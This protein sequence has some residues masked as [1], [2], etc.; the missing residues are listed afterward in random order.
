MIPHSDAQQLAR[1]VRALEPLAEEACSFVQRQLKLAPLAL[2]ASLVLSPGECAC[3]TSAM[4]ADARMIN[5]TRPRSQIRSLRSR[6]KSTTRLHGCR[7][8]ST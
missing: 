7:Q 1:A 2:L 3:C 8:A 6:K 5:L 4:T